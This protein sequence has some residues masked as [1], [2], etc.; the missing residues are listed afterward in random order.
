[1]SSSDSVQHGLFFATSPRNKLCEDSAP[2]GTVSAEAA[3]QPTHDDDHRAARWRSGLDTNCRSLFFTDIGGY[4]FL[5]APE[6]LESRA[7]IQK[8]GD[9]PD[10]K[11]PIISH[12]EISP[13]KVRAGEALELIVTVKVAPT[14]HIYAVG[15]S[16]GPGV[17]TTSIVTLPNGVEADSEWTCPQPVRDTGG[18]MIYQG[19]QKFRRRLRA[20]QGVLLGPIDLKCE[21]GYQAC[22]PFSCRLPTK[23]DLTAKGDVRN[24]LGNN[25]VLPVSNG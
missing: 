2:G 1:M 4:K 18:Q 10:A 9:V 25:P 16:R 21:F 20:A 11:H 8:V 5:V 17:P 14:W 6:S 23:V 12:A 3:R 24:S 22:D 13:A 15:G 19:T 7:A